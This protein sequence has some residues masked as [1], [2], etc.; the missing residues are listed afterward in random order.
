MT[1]HKSARKESP[2]EVFHHALK[3][4][5]EIRA[6]AQRDFGYKPKCK[7]GETEEQ[8]LKRWRFERR[9]LDKETDYLLEILRS[10]SAHIALANK[11]Y[12]TTW[13][14]YSERRLNQTQAIAECGR[15]STELQYIIEDYGP[16]VNKFIPYDALIQKEINLLKAWRKPDNRYI[17]ELKDAPGKEK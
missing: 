5:R 6:L 14:E 8:R 7:N 10:M 13:A 15:L 9:E 11:I 17:A 3:M 12:P 1:I 4:R 16:D 2:F